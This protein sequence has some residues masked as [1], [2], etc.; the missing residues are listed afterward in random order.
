MSEH[1]T[2]DILGWSNRFPAPSLAYITPGVTD[3]LFRIGP[4]VLLLKYWCSERANPGPARHDRRR[5]SHEYQYS[6][7]GATERCPI[8]QKFRGIRHLLN[9]G[10]SFLVLIFEGWRLVARCYTGCSPFSLPMHLATICVDHIG[11]SAGK[12]SVSQ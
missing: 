2:C 8:S 12:S 4:R 11:G 3:R 5:G 10:A 1:L 6:R 9:L 7:I